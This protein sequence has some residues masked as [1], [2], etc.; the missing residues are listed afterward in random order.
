VI[1]LCHWTLRGLVDSHRR[2]KKL[3]SP[4]LGRKCK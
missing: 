2:L 3:L 4:S 1:I